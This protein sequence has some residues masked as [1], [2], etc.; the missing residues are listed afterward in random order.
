MNYYKKILKEQGEPAAKKY[1]Q[2][3]RGKVKSKHGG[4]F[5]DPKVAKKAVEKRWLNHLTNPHRRSTVKD[6]SEEEL[7]S[8][9]D[10]LDAA[11][12]DRYQQDES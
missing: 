9:Q 12:E 8:R 1:M 5:N 6:M 4:G 3:L 10:M 11:E 7:L 2:E